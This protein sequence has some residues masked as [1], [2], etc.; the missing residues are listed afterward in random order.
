VIIESPANPTV[1]LLR[2]LDLPKNIKAQGLFVVEG[3]RAVE[4]GLASG[5]V[6]EVALYNRELLGRTE[7]GRALIKRLEGLQHHGAKEPQIA[8]ATERALGAAS[9]TR[10]PQGVI[11]AFPVVRWPDPSG[12]IAQRGN[13]LGL[14]CDNIQDPGNLGTILRTAEAAGVACVWLST[15]CTFPFSPKV[16]RAGM[17]AHFRLP[18]YPEV[19]W[20]SLEADLRKGGLPEGRVYSTDAQATRAYD[21]VDW[22]QASVLMVSNEAHGVSE[23]ARRFMASY[24]GAAISIPMSGGTESLNASIA[25]AVVL[26][27]AA[28]QRRTLSGSA[29][30]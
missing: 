23:D 2:S 19:S 4:D 12:V 5:R 22:S 11:A 7:R 6:P 21:E 25:A 20:T 28:R 16:V 13:F 1:K 26:F 3:V 14:V 30:L 10:H 29:R 27:E 17:G 18:T 9:D 15:G 24:S 8:E